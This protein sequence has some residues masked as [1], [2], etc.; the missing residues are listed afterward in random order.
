MVQ[1]GELT[2]PRLHSLKTINIQ[3]QVSVIL[4]KA[5]TLSHY[6]IRIE[7]F[8]SQVESD[9]SQIISKELESTV[10]FSREFFKNVTTFEKIFHNHSLSFTL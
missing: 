9:V 3:T 6:T 10:Y 2:V 7:R 5:H 8:N 1:R 4:N